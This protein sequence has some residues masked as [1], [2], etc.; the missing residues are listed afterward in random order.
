MKLSLTPD[1]FNAFDPVFSNGGSFGGICRSWL[2]IGGNA[3]GLGG[4]FF[5]AFRLLCIHALKATPKLLVSLGI[6]T[7]R[8]PHIVDR[9]HHP[10]SVSNVQMSNDGLLTPHS[11]DDAIIC[12]VD[13]AIQL[14]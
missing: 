7:L 3:C 11:P 4:E 10:L 2:G 5:V 12:S 9:V 8:G 14:T 13:A 6:L 1:A